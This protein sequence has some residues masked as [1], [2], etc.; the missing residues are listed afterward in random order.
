MFLPNAYLFTVDQWNIQGWNWFSQRIK[1][2]FKIGFIM[3]INT[4]DSGGVK[5]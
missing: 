4:V 5:G 3:R 2:I 1:D